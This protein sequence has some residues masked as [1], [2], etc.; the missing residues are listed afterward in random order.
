M[1]THVEV[2]CKKIRQATSLLSVLRAVSTG[3]VSIKMT[4]LD[5]DSILQQ[6]LYLQL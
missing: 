4:N 3:R 1:E 6:T 2:E 5:T